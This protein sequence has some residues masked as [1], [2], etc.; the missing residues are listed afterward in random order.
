MRRFVFC[1]A[2][3]ASFV[4]TALFAAQVAEPVEAQQSICEAR[5]A[6]ASAA[7]AN[8]WQRVYSRAADARARLNDV[9]DIVAIRAFQRSIVELVQSGCPADFSQFD[10]RLLWQIGIRGTAASSAGGAE[11]AQP[12]EG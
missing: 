2:V 4:P 6:S 7:H 10:R 1:F 9:R 12:N 3:A 8:Y 11:R 5:H